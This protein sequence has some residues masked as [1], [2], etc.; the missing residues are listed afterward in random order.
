MQK[1]KSKDTKSDDTNIEY[2]DQ[3]ISD[4]VTDRFTNRTPDWTEL[5]KRYKN[6]CRNEL[7]SRE[8]I[9]SFGILSII[10]VLLPLYSYIFTIFSCLM[11]CLYMLHMGHLDSLSKFQSIHLSYYSAIAYSL[12]LYSGVT[13]GSS[14]VSY[15]FTFSFITILIGMIGF[16]IHTY[17]QMGKDLG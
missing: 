11:G 8:F 7:I 3:D 1:S 15:F 14:L 9:F 2:R 16:V 4:E 12:I 5:I 6:V 13:I 17:H 10:F